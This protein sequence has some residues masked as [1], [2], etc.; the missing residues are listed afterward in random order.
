VTWGLLGVAA[1]LSLFAPRLT[2]AQVA[3]AAAPTSPQVAY[4][5]LPLV[6]EANHGQIASPVQFLARGQGYTL[7]L[8]PTEAMLAFARH[9]HSSASPA[10]TEQLAAPVVRM[11]LLGA[12][13]APQVMG[14]EVL[15]GKVHYV[16][17]RDPTHW[18]THVPTYAKVHYRA[19]YPGIDL[20][21]YGNHGQLEFDFV[22]APGADPTRI[23]L[24]FRGADRVDVDPQGDLL[25]RIGGDELRLHQPRIYQDA[26][27]G[28]QV[29]PGRY[30]VLPPPSDMGQREG[31]HHVGIDV[32]T[33]DPSQPLIIDP[34]L[35][36]ATYLGGGA[37]DAGRGI[38]VDATGAAYIVGETMSDDFPITPGVVQSQLRGASDI[39]VAKLAPDG[40]A[41]V[42][43]T[44]L[45]GAAEDFGR[46]IAVDATGAAYVT[47][48]TA[49]ADFPTT[50]GAVQPA[51]GGFVDAFVAKLA[52]DGAALIYATFL[53]GGD[54]DGGR[55]VVVDAAGAAYVTGDAS[56]DFPVTPGAV[57]PTLHGFRDAFVTKLA[58]AGTA[59]VYSTYLGGS[60]AEIGNG[61]AVDAA[62]AAYL[63]G[64]TASPDFPTTP[65]VVQPSFGGDEDAF[66][67]KLTPDGTA[68]VYATY[69]GGSSF[70]I[71]QG[72]A[73]DGTGAAYVTGTT[74]SFGGPNNFPTT[75]GAVQPTFGGLQDAFVAKLT[76]DGTTLVYATYLGGSQFDGGQGIAVDAAGAAY[77]MGA[78]SS[79]EFPTTPDAIQP[80]LSGDVDSFI[81]TLTPSGVGLAFST[82]LGGS[83]SDLGMGISGQIIAVD[84]A[85]AVYV[86]WGTD[87]SDFPTTAGVVQPKLGGGTDAFLAK[88]VLQL[89]PE[90][91]ITIRQALFVDRLALLAVMATSSAAP[92]AEL[93]VT[94]PECFL[95]VPMSQVKDR[96]LLVR[97]VP[98]CEDLDGHTAIVTSSRGGLARAPLR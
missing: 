97:T 9:G 28:T 34:V 40:T 18:R 35:G 72:I 30:V 21:Y 73:V 77:V 19:V 64:E 91:V 71:G 96:Y 16:R 70:D 7:W 65:G 38:A 89:P 15:P 57:Q 74:G 78:T 42:Y 61:I 86:T 69:L 87:S 85:G 80:T 55:A 51:L 63:T 59:L 27:S 29:I 10:A 17:G 3:A 98:E 20:V 81:T 5:R 39:F 14:K 58:P 32:D 53:G 75:P 44:Y 50:P 13:P 83:G 52:P 93:F 94:V 76:P 79:S 25:L 43:A 49:S 90:D 6:F 31:M 56:A 22:V 68:L 36:Y 66:V 24:G 47:G 41:L 88:I 33:Y 48:E 67:A 12:H 46:G 84:A 8:T 62:G 4:S 11:T 37:D 26:D 23:S 92:D 54:F 82:Y 95:R 60:S 1:L 45:G 2:G